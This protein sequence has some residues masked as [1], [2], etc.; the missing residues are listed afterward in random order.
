MEI[1]FLEMPYYV[2]NNLAI[3]ARPPIHLEIQRHRKSPVGVL[4]SSFR[5][6][7]PKPAFKPYFPRGNWRKEWDSNPR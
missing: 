4:R 2:C 1:C 7:L 5:A 3:K 6:G